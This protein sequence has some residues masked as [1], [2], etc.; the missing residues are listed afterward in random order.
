[1][2]N[3]LEDEGNLGVINLCA[4]KVVVVAFQLRVGKMI[5]TR[6]V[7]QLSWLVIG[8]RHLRARVTIQQ[9]ATLN[10][11]LPILASLAF[12][13]VMRIANR[14]L[15]EREELSEG[16]EREMSLRILFLINHCGG[17]CLLGC[18]SLKDLLFNSSCGNETVDETCA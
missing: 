12:K 14:V 9:G 5:P 10:H 17:Q 8:P 4:K 3:V 15:I 16:L 11:L 18:L 13:R 7:S 6:D 2:T 1:M